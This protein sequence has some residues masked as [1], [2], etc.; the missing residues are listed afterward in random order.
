MV[1][2]YFVKIHKKLTKTKQIP[3][4]LPA[5]S[6]NQFP[7]L[8]DNPFSIWAMVLQEL[9]FYR[10]SPPAVSPNARPVKRFFQKKTRKTLIC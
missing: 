5:G 1:V 9:F 6:E 8:L 10:T 2:C 3:F 4:R 7:L